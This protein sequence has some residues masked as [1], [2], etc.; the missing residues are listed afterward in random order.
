VLRSGLLA[1]GGLAGLV[2]MAGFAEKVR[3]GAALPL[4]PT[5]N[6]TVK[7]YGTNWSLSAPDL[8]RGDLPKR[9]DTVFVTGALK[10]AAGEPAGAFFGTVIHLDANGG[11]GP[12]SSALQET[13]TFQLPGGNLVG[14]GVNAPDGE[15]VF[16]IIGGTG[17]YSGVT[18]SYVGRQSPLDTGG[19][20]TAEF[21]F[22]FNSGR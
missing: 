14:M 2:G 13:H 6:A 3:S 11:H 12:Y 1:I 9:G 21:T 4:A 5:G 8:R 19:D 20:G 22:T 10:D 7:V 17:R 16:A 18:G 15:G